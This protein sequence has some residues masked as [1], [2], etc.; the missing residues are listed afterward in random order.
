MTKSNKGFTLIELLVVI[1]IIGIL[2]SVVLASLNTA[3]QKARDSRRTSDVQNLRL[4]LELYADANTGSYPTALA[5]LAPTYIA[6]IPTDPGSLAQS[7]SGAYYYKGSGT[8][9]HIGAD[10]EN[11]SS[12]PSNDANCDSTATNAGA[13]F[14]P[15][16]TS[17]FTGATAARYDQ[18]Q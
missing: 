16:L 7:G 12:I 13:C 4:A 11:A 9:Y 2:S 1:A 10:F 6:V 18:R 3:R 14:S 5:D 15:A 8:Q 17:G